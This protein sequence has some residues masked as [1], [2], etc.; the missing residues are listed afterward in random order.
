MTPCFNDLKSGIQDRINRV[1][2]AKDA[3]DEI[4]LC[5]L[6]HLGRSW[7]Y[8]ILVLKIKI[9]MK[10]P[11][12]ILLFFASQL[13]GQDHLRFEEEVFNIQKKYD[14]IWDPAAKTIVFT[15]SSSIRIWNGL[16]ELFPG[17]LVVNTGFGGSQASDLMAYTDALILKYHPWKVFIYEGD[18]DLSAGKKP[19]QI[20]RDTEEII[21]TINSIYP[22]TRIVLISAKPSLS[23][24]KL[25]GKYL[26]LNR[27]FQRISHRDS[28]VDYANIWDTMLLEGKVRPDIFLE[29]GLH[30]NNKGYELWYPV[31]KKYVE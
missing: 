7:I 2:K 20:R 16:A 29:D 6:L 1:C 14:T 11:V 17:Y 27:K 24:W 9:L 19:G 8:G 12:V 31:I 15:G 28:S 10:Y 22:E 13:F 25:K 30:M 3:N 26:R 21:R 4:L 18:N 23:R 5:D